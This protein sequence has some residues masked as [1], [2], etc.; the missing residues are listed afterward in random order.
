MF[1]FFPSNLGKVLFSVYTHA[2]ARQHLDKA[3]VLLFFTYQS[4]SLSILSI[5]LLFHL[6]Y[7]NPLKKIH[8]DTNWDGPAAQAVREAEDCL[9]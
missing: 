3:R 9:L 6:P 8:T 1:F 7:V 4:V 5:L 2:H